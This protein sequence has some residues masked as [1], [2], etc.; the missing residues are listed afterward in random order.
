MAELHK[1]IILGY[2]CRIYV[3]IKMKYHKIKILL[4]FT[5]KKLINFS[6]IGIIDFNGGP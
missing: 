3:K 2:Y 5:Q 6:L 4:D 1:N